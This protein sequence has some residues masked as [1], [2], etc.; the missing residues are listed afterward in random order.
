[1]PKI[2]KSPQANWRNNAIQFPRLIAELEATGTFSIPG[3]LG[4]LASEMGL[5]VDEV[6]GLID[7][8]QQEWDKIKE[9]I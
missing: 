7:R 9:K 4:T 8:A 1:M 5:T 3:V 6:C 2:S